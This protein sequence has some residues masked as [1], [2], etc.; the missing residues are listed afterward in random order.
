MTP[1]VKVCPDGHTTTIHSHSHSYPPPSYD[2][3]VELFALIALIC[4]GQVGSL[5]KVYI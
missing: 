5:S 4:I 3:V 1:P 2:Q